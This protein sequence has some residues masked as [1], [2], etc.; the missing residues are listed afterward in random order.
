MHNPNDLI[1][2]MLASEKPIKVNPDSVLV[3]DVGRTLA[4]MIRKDRREKKRAEHDANLRE[5][6]VY[7]RK[8]CKLFK[9][10]R[11]FKKTYEQ[12]TECVNSRGYEKPEVVQPE[13]VN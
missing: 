13:V 8:R 4:Q 9:E 7:C 12:Q 6:H 2:E 11:C 5:N 10:R 1:Q 3:D